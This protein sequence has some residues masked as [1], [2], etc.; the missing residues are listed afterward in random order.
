MYK[1]KTDSTGIIARYKARVI[2]QGFLQKKD[3]DYSESY[4]PVANISLI[5]LLISMSVSHNWK[6]HYLDVKCAYLYGNLK[7][8]IYMKLPQGHK[9]Y[10]M[11]VAKLLKP[12]Y[13]L[14]QPG[15]NWNNAINK[16]LIKHGFKEL[17]ASNCVYVYDNDLI[18]TLYVDDII[19]FAPSIDKINEINS[20]LASEYEIRDLSRASY[21]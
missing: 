7:E 5:R 6:I 10:D 8:E 17:Q 4:A 16:F 14:K 19:L 20:L 3:I 13:G 11:K 21:L 2:A 18:L 12:I 9:D 15:L 1:V